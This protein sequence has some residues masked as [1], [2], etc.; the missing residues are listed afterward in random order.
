MQR[1]LLCNSDEFQHINTKRKGVY[2]S[3]RAEYFNNDDLSNTYATLLCMY[4]IMNGLLNWL[5]WST[6]TA[7]AFTLMLHVTLEMAG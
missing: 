6:G 7:N 3:W 1:D 2:F 4:P 5:K